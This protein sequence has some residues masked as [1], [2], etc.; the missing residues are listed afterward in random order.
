MKTSCLF[1]LLIFFTGIFY[2]CE[3]DDIEPQKHKVEYYAYN[4]SQ[5]KKPIVITFKRGGVVIASDSYDFQFETT[6]KK[7][8]FFITCADRDQHLYGKIYVDNREV[9]SLAGQAYLDLEYI[10]E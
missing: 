7:V 3:K 1:F 4:M 5:E 9:V 10:I 6:E 2:S 8:G